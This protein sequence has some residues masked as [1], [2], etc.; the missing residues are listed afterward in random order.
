MQRPA[1][2]RAMYVDGDAAMELQSN[3]SA[4]DDGT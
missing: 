2:A 4:D 1:S 3:Q